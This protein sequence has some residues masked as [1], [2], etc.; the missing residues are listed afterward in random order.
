VKYYGIFAV[1]AKHR[2]RPVFV[3]WR[4]SAENVG[5]VERVFCAYSLGLRA[6]EPNDEYLCRQ[7]RIFQNYLMS[8]QRICGLA[9]EVYLKKRIQLSSEGVVGDEFWSW[10]DAQ[11]QSLDLARVWEFGDQLWEKYREHPGTFGM[12]RYL[13]DRL[14]RHLNKFAILVH[15][16][17]RIAQEMTNENVAYQVGRTF[18]EYLEAGILMADVHTGNLGFVAE[19]PDDNDFAPSMPVVT[20]P[21]HVLILK[22]ELSQ[23]QIE[24]L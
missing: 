5:N 2:G 7:Y 15:I 19:R 4:E 1:E 23:A 10:I 20:D 24:R 17:E 14:S 13:Q 3:L 8:W 22:R 18:G 11:L 6:Q 16:A 21:G 12:H 9:R